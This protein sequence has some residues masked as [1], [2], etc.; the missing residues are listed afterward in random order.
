[1]ASMSDTPDSRYERVAVAV[2]GFGRC[3]STMLMR[4]LD[5]G[6]IPPV[7]GSQ[8]IS[9][10]LPTIDLL[11]RL[12][13]KD[14]IGHASKILDFVIHPDFRM[15]LGPQWRFL[16]LDRNRTQQARSQIKFIETIGGVPLGPDAEAALVES[17]RRDRPR[18]LRLLGA[19]G[20]VTTFKYEHVLTDPLGAAYK[21][22]QAVEPLDFDPVAANCVVHDRDPACRPD[23]NFEL[24]GRA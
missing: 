21:I 14:V 10:E 9:Y 17:Y 12:D 3:G 5:A 11:G 23:L 19:L 18:A 15:V 22:Q 24:T 20:Q 6:G 2:C 7:E 16:W 8:P 1:M 13:T 4:M